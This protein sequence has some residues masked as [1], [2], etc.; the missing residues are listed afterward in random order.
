ME[1]DDGVP[2]TSFWLHTCDEQI[3]RSASAMSRSDPEDRGFRVDPDAGSGFRTK[4]SDWMT[5]GRR[6]PQRFLGHA[7]AR[8]TLP[9]SKRGRRD[10]RPP[11]PR[12]WNR[13]ICVSSHA[14]SALLAHGPVPMPA[15]LKH[16]VVLR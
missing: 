12:A 11:R 4:A 1:R 16:R 9:S 5:A 14:A 3:F 13:P 2:E 15:V 8:T 6:E 10:G 7:R